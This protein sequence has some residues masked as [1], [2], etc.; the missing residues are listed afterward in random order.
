MPSSR[1]AI[2]RLQG[3][4]SP[5]CVVL[6]PD[7]LGQVPSLGLQPM[8]LAFI[9]QGSVSIGNLQEA[10]VGGTVRLQTGGMGVCVCVCAC[11]TVCMHRTYR[12]KPSCINGQRVS[13]QGQSSDPFSDRQIVRHSSFDP[14]PPTAHNL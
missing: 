13:G 4:P 12:L 5:G 7:G 1:N 6:S 10:A 14:L 3:S 8:T 2:G 11:I 9:E